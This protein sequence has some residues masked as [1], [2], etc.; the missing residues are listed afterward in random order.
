MPVAFCTGRVIDGLRSG[1][2]G[3]DALQDCGTGNDLPLPT[4]VLNKTGVD[5]TPECVQTALFG[6]GLLAVSRRLELCFEID[7]F[8]GI[9]GGTGDVEPECLFLRTEE[10]ES[11]SLSSS[12]VQCL[13]G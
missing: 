6:I 9:G 8:G 2:G 7:S 1:R 5:P 11:A 4:G 13:N 3:F 10:L 12:V